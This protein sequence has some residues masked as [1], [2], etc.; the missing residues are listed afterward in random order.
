MDLRTEVALLRITP[1]GCCSYCHRPFGSWVT[2][3][4]R[5]RF[6]EEVREHV[7][8]KCLGGRIIVPACSLCN[9][10]KGSLVFESLAEIQNFLLDRLLEDGSIVLV[11]GRRIMTER[12]VRVEAVT[13]EEREELRLEVKA[14]VSHRRVRHRTLRE[15][16]RSA[17]KMRR[18]ATELAAPGTTKPPREVLSREQR[19]R[20]C[21]KWSHL[22]K[23]C[24]GPDL[25]NSPCNRCR[26]VGYP[27]LN[28]CRM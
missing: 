5:L 11:Y 12:E 17:T 27:H 23:N 10:L 26:K 18:L 8:P 4:G 14:L 19:C 6:L 3:R 21:L 9:Q 22:T 15:M 2:W 20:S 13:D 7:F 28:P 16:K 24:P 25:R 1:D